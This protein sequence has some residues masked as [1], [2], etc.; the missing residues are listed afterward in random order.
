MEKLL[1]EVTGATAFGM[2]GLLLLF[3]AYDVQK[4]AM[5]RQARGAIKVNPLAGF[6]RTGSFISW[7]HL[8]GA[9]F[10]V[11]ALVLLIVAYQ[12]MR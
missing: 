3:R 12:R 9:I 5:R 11:A 6:V 1:Q 8:L 4:L 7:L 2:G 10:L